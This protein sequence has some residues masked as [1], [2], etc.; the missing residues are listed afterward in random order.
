MTEVKKENDNVILIG[1]K[2]IMSY[3]LAVITQFG[4]GQKEVRIRARGRAISR[5]V[6]VANIVRKKYVKEAQIKSITI[7]SEEK[8]NPQT[9]KKVNVSTIEIV[10]AK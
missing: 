2:P 4:A 8:E 1:K 9:G 3:I 5:A 7:D 6:D 10:L